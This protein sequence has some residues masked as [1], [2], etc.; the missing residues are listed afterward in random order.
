MPCYFHGLLCCLNW[1][2]FQVFGMRVAKEPCWN[3]LWLPNRIVCRH[4]YNMLHLTL[5]CL[6]T[7]SSQVNTV[8][9]ATV[10]SNLFLFCFVLLP[11]SCCNYAKAAYG[12]DTSTGTKWQKFLPLDEVF[13]TARTMPYVNECLQS[14]QE[15]P[16]LK[17]TSD[18]AL[19]PW[20]QLKRRSS[21]K[22]LLQQ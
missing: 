6:L 22:H 3:E 20:L 21:P 8:S 19:R 1:S 11:A 16:K 4:F 2:H 10:L 15:V 13:R 5:L 9:E 18:L 17:V 12:C 7:D 14:C